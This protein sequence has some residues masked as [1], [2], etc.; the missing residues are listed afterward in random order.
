MNLYQKID[1]D[2]LDIIIDKIKSYLDREQL[3]DTYLVG[4]IPLKLLDMLSCCP[5]L[6][7]SLGKLGF[8]IRSFAIYRTVPETNTPI[9][10]DNTIEY[11]SRINIPILNCDTSSTV[12]YDAD[13]LELRDQHSLNIKYIQC[14]NAVE[15][16]RVTID[17][18]TIL[19]IN[20]P[21]QVLMDINRSP[22]ICLTISV[23]PDPITTI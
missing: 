8:T 19:R 18:A 12:F 22:R 20:K 14:I 1:I 23:L 15:I 10:I 21:H 3:I 2:N 5:E 9:H 16:D 4:Y 13:V 11:T 17:K 7:K 6:V